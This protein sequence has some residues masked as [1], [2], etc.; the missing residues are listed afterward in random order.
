M[1]VFIGCRQVEK[2]PLQLAPAAFEKQ[3]KEPQVQLV[4]LRT[5]EEFKTGYIEGAL[6]LNWKDS[7]AFKA[8]AQQLQQNKPVYLYCKSGGR[9]AKAADWFL[10]QGFKEVV[11]LKG[12]IESWRSSGLPILT[13]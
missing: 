6:L 8:G 4:D 9:S 1:L 3:A 2:K 7:V 10:K 5:P 13:K 12:G 11:E